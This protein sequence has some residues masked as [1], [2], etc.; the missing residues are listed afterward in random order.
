MPK[1]VVS[2]RPALVIVHLSKPAYTREGAITDK[3]GGCNCKASVL[4]RMSVY[5]PVRVRQADRE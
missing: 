4:E 3:T 5:V 1:A 2:Y